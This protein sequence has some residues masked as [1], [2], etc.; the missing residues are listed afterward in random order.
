[1]LNDWKPCFGATNYSETVSQTI[2]LTAPDVEDADDYTL[3]CIS[4][5]Y[6]D[7]SVNGTLGNCDGTPNDDA[8][9]TNKAKVSIR[10]VSD[11]GGGGGGGGGINADG[12]NIT[13]KFLVIQFQMLH[14]AIVSRY[15]TSSNMT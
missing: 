10:V 6:F 7:Q 2:T 12:W 14:N 9:C 4:L 5:Q 13:V 11:G 8:D 15:L 1:M 3:T